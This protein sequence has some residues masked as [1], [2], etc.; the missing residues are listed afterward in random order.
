[1]EG[2]KTVSW[3]GPLIVFALFVALCLWCAWV[4]TRAEARRFERQGYVIT[5]ELGVERVAT[6]TPIF[7]EWGR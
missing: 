1:M 2:K 6:V 5:N 7:E 4:G 3:W